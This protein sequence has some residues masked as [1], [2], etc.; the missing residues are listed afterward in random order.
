ML[1]PDDPRLE[2]LVWSWAVGE[3]AVSG[4]ALQGTDGRWVSRPCTEKHRVA[5][6]ADGQWTVSAKAV[7]WDHADR[8]CAFAAPWNGRENELLRRAAHGDVWVRSQVEV[9]P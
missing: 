3:P 6:Y 5:C 8:Q 1:H 7:R 2:T 9:A 4:C